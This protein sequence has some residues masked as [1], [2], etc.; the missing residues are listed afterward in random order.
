MAARRKPSKPESVAEKK[1]RAARDRSRKPK[2]RALGAFDRLE[3]PDYVRRMAP[4]TVAAT[5]SDL[6]DLAAYLQREDGRR[7]AAYAADSNVNQAVA[8]I[9]RLAAFT[10]RY[11]TWINTE[12]ST[13]WVAKRI[14]QAGD[15]RAVSSIER[16]VRRARA[17]T[18]K[19]QQP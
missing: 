14:Q 11:A 3:V 12:R 15:K 1:V 18:K 17:I 8:A 7:A 19:V 13:A 4:A 5:N 2:Q 16:H 9:D 6:T 10:A